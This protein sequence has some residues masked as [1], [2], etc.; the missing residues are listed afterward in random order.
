MQTAPHE[1]PFM[2]PAELAR[3]LRITTKCLAD[4]RSANPRRGPAF[5]KLNDGTNSAVRY[6]REAVAAWIE[7]RT[8]KPDSQ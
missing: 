8:T 3:L 5:V 1:T 7:S 2:S 4:W 6:P